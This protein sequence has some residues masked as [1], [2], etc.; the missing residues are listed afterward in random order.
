MNLNSKNPR[1]EDKGLPCGRPISIF[2]IKKKQDESKKL[3]KWQLELKAYLDENG[4]KYSEQRWKIAKLI[5]EKR[6]HFTAQEIVQSVIIAHPGIGAATV[7]RNLKMLCEAKILKETLIDANGVIIFLDCNDIF[8]FHDTNIESL[9]QEVTDRLKFTE[10][11]H[12]HILYA[13]CQ[14]QKVIK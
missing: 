10:V 7:Y 6:G 11:R 14:Y 12:R 13:K 2:P 1:V 4:L 9:Q 8:E 3:K 5:L